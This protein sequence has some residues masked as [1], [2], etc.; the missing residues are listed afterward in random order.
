MMTQKLRIAL[1]GL[2]DIAQ[3]A[4]LPL[5][6]QHP[7]ISP[8][9]CTR[10]QATLARLA[11]QYRV[12]ETYLNIDALIAAQPDAVMIH[13]ATN[14]HFA[15]ASA[16]L[17]AK[18]PTF[19]D[20][21]ISDNLSEVGQLVEL[22]KA[23][24]TPLCSGFNRRF[25]PLLQPLTTQPLTHLRWQKN[26]HDLPGKVREFVFD[27]FIHVVDS[28]LHF[29]EP[30]TDIKPEIN[31]ILKDKLLAALFLRIPTPNGLIEGSMNRISG[32]TFER[33]EA[34]A[35]NQHWQIDN[36][37]QG[38][39]AHQGVLTP[40]QFSDWEATLYKRGFND[41]LNSW[42]AQIKN[43]QPAHDYLDRLLTTHQLCEKIVK[44]IEAKMSL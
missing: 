15:L 40:L 30:L 26:R 28:L 9:L 6:C 20:K 24:N 19:V 33:V 37:R 43:G 36:L 4:W 2:G 23:Q 21:P 1:V 11:T 32:Q 38:H 34:F 25:A 13:S 39:H 16:T 5:V 22:A 41:L 44:Y 35:D 8:I 7:D 17:K 42:L 18:I 3:K 31:F 10:N 29:S 14:S 27:D 12:E